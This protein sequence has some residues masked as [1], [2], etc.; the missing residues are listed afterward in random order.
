MT[1]ATPADQSFSMDRLKAIAQDLRDHLGKGQNFDRLAED[2]LPSWYTNLDREIAREIIRTCATAVFTVLEPIVSSSRAA[3]QT[4]FKDQ[5]MDLRIGDDR[6]TVRAHIETRPPSYE[7]EAF[8]RAR[9]EYGNHFPSTKDTGSGQ[10]P[11]GAIL[12]GRHEDVNELT[13]P[14]DDAAEGTQQ[15]TPEQAS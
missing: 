15:G 13:L 4:S 3:R 6:D 2:G 7:P 11:E 5:V 9:A 12:S 1:D 10:Q 8:H 14:S